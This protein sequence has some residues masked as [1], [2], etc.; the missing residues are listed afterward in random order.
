MSKTKR[1][2]LGLALVVAGLLGGAG[3]AAASNPP[4]TH[5]QPA[6]ERTAEMTH[7]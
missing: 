2:V 7:N 5:N 6:A 1:R 3:V 4:M